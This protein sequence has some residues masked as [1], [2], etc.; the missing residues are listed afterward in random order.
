MTAEEL[1][2]LPRGQHRYE[3]VKGEL[4]TMSPSG[5]EH[6]FVIMNLAA[7]LATFVKEH[8]LGTVLGAETGFKLESDP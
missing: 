3:L 8:K 6:G 1:I 2:H 4:L 7:P 5:Y